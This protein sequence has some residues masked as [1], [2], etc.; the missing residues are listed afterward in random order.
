MTQKS[1][2]GRSRQRKT[3][4]LVRFTDIFA[5][6]LITMGGISTIIAVSIVCVLL[7]VVVIPLF[8]SATLTDRGGFEFQGRSYE[9]IRHVAADEYRV[10]GLSFLQ[11]GQ[12]ET[13]LF[14][15]GTRIE[16]RQIFSEGESCTAWSFP[17][18]GNAAFGFSDGSVRVG[19]IE[20]KSSFLEQGGLSD[21]FEHMK[22]GAIAVNEK[23][24]VQKM[25]SSQVRRQEL[26]VDLGE[27]I[28]VSPDSPI[29][30]MDVTIRP[31]GPVLAALAA[32]GTLFIKKASSKKNL[33]TGKVKTVLSGGEV[34][35]S[36]DPADGK[37]QFLLLSGIADTVYVIWENGKLLRFD[38]R[39]PDAPTLAETLQVTS[40]PTAKVTAATFLIGK[41]S[42]AIGDARGHVNVWFR[43]KPK[44]AD[45]IVDGSMLVKAH[46]MPDAS[47]GAVTSL[48]S[49][50]RTRKLAVGY[51]DGSV[52]LFYVTV[53]RFLCEGRITDVAQS[54]ES[55][56]IHSLSMSPKD[57]GLFAVAGNRLY[58]WDIYAPHPEATFSSIFRPVWYEGYNTPDHTWQSSSGEDAFEPK[59]GLQRL[60]FG[61]I[62]A[63]FYAM[64][65]GTPLAILAAIYT[66]EFLHP[67]VKSYVKPTIE[68]MAS[69]P[70]VVLGF[71]AALVFAPFV[72]TIV[73][74]ILAG[75]VTV[76]AS[77][78]LGAYLWQLIPGETAISL[79]QIGHR[80][81]SAGR[82][83][84]PLAR[85]VFRLGGIRLIAVA[86]A[87]VVGVLLAGLIGKP[88]ESLLFSG[89]L[90]AWLDGQVGNGTGGWMILLLPVSAVAVLLFVTQAVNPQIRRFAAG[91]SR[92]RLARLDLLKYVASI[93]AILL[94]AYL[95]G[96]ALSALGFDP[97]GNVLGTY[98]QRNAMVVGFVMGF[99]VIPIIY[100]IS[101]DALSA[102]PQHLR[103]A[104]LGA[105]ATP[106]Q[107]TMRIIIPTAASGLF[108]AIMIGFGRAIGETMIVLMA[109]GNTPVAEWNIF[110]GMRTLSAT[111]AVELPEAVQDSTHYR[112]LFLAAFVLFVMTFLLNTVAEVVRQRFRKR[113]F[114]L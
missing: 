104:S 13:F 81:M 101:E 69:L 32:D 7:F 11:S 19:K 100:T 87:V 96:V 3:T 89:D 67:K 57:D 92:A 33:M 18:N 70:S 62:K 39:D 68:L 76:P 90:K 86:T 63:T 61:T 107:T 56:V 82:P 43:I 59:F 26:A 8:S 113:A 105:G 6:G 44:A 91:Y 21:E 83:T 5:R 55:A 66:S 22:P 110:N 77:I 17:G 84:S 51:A 99:A 88:V 48:S 73:P 95:A 52:R 47:A 4:R 23:S 12:L 72:E 93:F 35:L 45:K 64:L 108:S 94:L 1:F 14:S 109:A 38:T 74:E 24:V 40:D 10:M 36:L 2:T 37:P 15:D 58:R 75:I 111:I 80:S 50:A 25:P 20:F 97:R 28:K 46:S 71:L 102:V 30:L 49:S 65:F 29:E 85:L 112:M 31:D 41:T 42:I 79:L 16:S 114:Q 78:L 9:K 27:S 103:A 106:W 34:K 53:D 60:V 54:S 98:V